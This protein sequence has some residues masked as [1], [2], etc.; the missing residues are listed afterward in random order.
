MELFLF[1]IIAILSIYAGS[2]ADKLQ[3]SNT[4]TIAF[5]DWLAQN[6]MYSHHR[7]NEAYYQHITDIG[8][9]TPGGLYTTRQ[10]LKIYRH[11]NLK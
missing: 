9:N 3:E 11:Q 10:L 2:T 5:A 8:E 1:V 4:E 7:N 6:Y